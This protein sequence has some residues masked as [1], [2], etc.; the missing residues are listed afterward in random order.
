MLHRRLASLLACLVLPWATPGCAHDYAL[1]GRETPV[2]VWITAPEQAARGETITALVYVGGQKAVEG[3]ITFQPGKPTVILPSVTT[4]A[5]SVRVS[6]VLFD[7]AVSTNQTVGIE[8]E[9]WVQIVVRGRSASI[10]ATEE[11]PNPQMR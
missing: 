1:E 9:S 4:R 6:A 11:Q 5:G 10:R 7:G 8:G 3:P 2:H